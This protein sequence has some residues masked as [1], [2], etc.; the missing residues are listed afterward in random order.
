MHKD[1]RKT[2][3]A[4]RKAT[5]PARFS[6]TS[7]RLNASS[8]GS[9][10][11]F[12]GLKPVLPTAGHILY[13]MM[14]EQLVEGGALERGRA[15]RKQRILYAHQFRDARSELWLSCGCADGTA[16]AH[17]RQVKDTCSRGR[18][19]G[20]WNRGSGFRFRRMRICDESGT[21]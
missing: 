8:G 11:Y 5:P 13:I 6:V 4:R 1:H 20:W 15:R 3:E 10:A 19:R 14:H 17:L 9:R 21:M 16:S 18:A 7:R 2:L 12:S